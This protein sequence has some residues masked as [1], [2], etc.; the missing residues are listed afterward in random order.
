VFISRFRDIQAGLRISP[1]ADWIAVTPGDT[2]D[3]IPVWSP[4]GNLLYY[5]SARDGGLCIWAQRLDPAT[6]RP[7]GEP[8]AIYHMHRASRGVKQF[9]WEIPIGLS[10]AKEQLIFAQAERSGSIWLT[11]LH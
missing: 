6:K 5:V 4:D 1:L 2:K 11:S 9:G 3:T 7:L 10:V 8:W